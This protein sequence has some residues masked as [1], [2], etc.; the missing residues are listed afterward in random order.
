MVERIVVLV[1]PSQVPNQGIVRSQDSTE[2][3]WFKVSR[4][5]YMLMK[6]SC[7]RRQASGRDYDR[8]PAEVIGQP[9]QGPERRSGAFWW[10][11]AAQS[12]YSMWRRVEGMRKDGVDLAP[13]RIQ[14]H[15]AAN[16]EV[17]C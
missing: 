10:V 9:K 1:L 11:G 8:L 16:L 17:S 12:W 13:M 4:F 6:Y 5:C 3:S 2:R 14:D 7:D 15:L